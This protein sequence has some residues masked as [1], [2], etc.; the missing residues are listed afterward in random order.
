MSSIFDGMAAV[1][2]DT[3]GDTEPFT[4]TLA[5]GGPPVMIN[6][7]LETPALA[8]TGLSDTEIITADTELHVA[9]DDLPAGAGEGDTVVARG[10]TY[11]TKVAMPDGRGMVRIPLLKS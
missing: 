11:K 9:A 5:A 10:T 6:G 3:F 7:I 4:Y 8:I 2:R 1:F